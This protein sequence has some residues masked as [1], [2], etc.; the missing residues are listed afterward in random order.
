MANASDEFRLASSGIDH[1]GRLPRKYTGDGQGTKKDI[2]PPLEWYNVPEGTK[3]LALVVEDID[4]PDP[5]APLVPWTVWVVVNI[6]PTLKGLPEGFSG[7][8]GDMGGDYANVKEGH[9]DFKVPGWRAPKMPSS[10]HR[11]EFKLYALDEQVEL[12]NKVTK[13]KL[14]EAIDGH[15]VGEA[16]LMA[17][18]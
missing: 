9:N 14:L 10:G 5:E 6:P 11:F 7:K 8:E 13:E 1:E 16:V 2:S 15:V 17:V 18:N 4:A 12:G 3:T